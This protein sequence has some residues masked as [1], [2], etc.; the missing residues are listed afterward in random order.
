MKKLLSLCLA[1]LLLLAAVPALADNYDYIQPYSTVDLSVFKNAG[2][3]LTYLEMEYVAELTNPMEIKATV[4]S[5]SKYLSDDNY[6]IQMDLRMVWNG[7]T[8]VWVPRLIFKSQ[9]YKTY[10]YG[11]LE[12]VFI[13]VGENRYVVNAS[14]AS[15]STDSKNYTA[16]ESSVEPIGATGLEALRYIANTDKEVKV[17]FDN[18]GTVT[19][20]AA[21][22]TKLKNFLTL[23]ENA[24]V[25]EQP[26]FYVSTDDYSTLTK[27]NKD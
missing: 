12:K 22:V 25:F 4:A 11:A 24:G 7:S 5:G 9:G 8:C 26:G 18:R 3:K 19:L 23:C 16:S 14:G 1:M 10:A 21:D 6:T 13:K 15:R 17:A 20:K 27:F 2:Y